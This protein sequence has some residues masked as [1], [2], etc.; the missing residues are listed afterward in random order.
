MQVWCDL[1]LWGD[2]DVIVQFYYYLVFVWGVVVICCGM[3]KVQVFQ[4]DVVVFLLGYDE[5]DVVL[6]LV[7]ECVFL[8]KFGL[9]EVIF[10]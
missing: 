2:L 5:G 7:G 10:D 8:Y 1:K 9:Q 6:W 4:C 3:G